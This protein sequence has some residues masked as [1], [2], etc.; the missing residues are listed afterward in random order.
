MPQT[1]PH[2]NILALGYRDHGKTTLTNA[3]AKVLTKKGQTVVQT[4]PQK[5]NQRFF[6]LTGDKITGVCRVSEIIG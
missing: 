1:K 2:L 3:I 5:E 6:M 4:I